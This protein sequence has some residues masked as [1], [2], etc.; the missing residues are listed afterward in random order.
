MAGFVRIN[1]DNKNGD[2]LST[3]IRISNEFS[4]YKH[5]SD[6]IPNMYRV[7]LIVPSEISLLESYLYP[8]LESIVRHLHLIIACNMGERRPKILK[9]GGICWKCSKC[10]HASDNVLSGDRNGCET[11][12][13]DEVGKLYQLR[14]DKDRL[15]IHDNER[16]IARITK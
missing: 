7:D 15:I 9:N 1:F 3:L 11:C 12:G 16:D 4:M 13:T 5:R 8:S 14:I 10:Y 2:V 6:N